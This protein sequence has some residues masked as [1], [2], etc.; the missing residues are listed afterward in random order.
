MLQAL[1]YL[2]CPLLVL[3]GGTIGAAVVAAACLAVL[4]WPRKLSNPQIPFLARAMSMLV[5]LV[6][7][8]DIGFALT[9]LILLAT[10]RSEIEFGAAELEDA[11]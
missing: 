1:I 10:M 6:A 4:A 7:S 2:N 5:S 11:P 3:W 9:A 8:Y